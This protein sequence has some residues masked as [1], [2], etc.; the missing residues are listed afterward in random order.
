MSDS[1]QDFRI[2]WH[3]GTLVVIPG[4]DIE[5]MKWD[6]IE[7]AAKILSE[8]RPQTVALILAHL[9]PDHCASLMRVLP[10]SLRS[11][12]IQRMVDLQPVEQSIIEELNN[13]MRQRVRAHAT[14]VRP[15][16]AGKEKVAKLLQSIDRDSADRIL[17][18]LDQK[19]AP[20]A[21]EIKEAMFRFE[22]LT[23][24]HN[25]DLRTLYQSIAPE[26]WHLALLGKNNP[27]LPRIME[28]LS[29]RAQEMLRDD[30]QSLGN[31]VRLSSV[32]SAQKYILEE[33]LRLLQ[34]GTIERPDPS[35]PYV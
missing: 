21:S 10:Q 12:L 6:L 25:P 26:H 35:D 4:G 14:R 17:N 18:E 28:I 23:E 13:T 1:N 33:A 11:E 32:L 19:N 9:S 16:M 29:E 24:F 7:Q 31:K 20:L 15:P 8:E 27:M 22:D 5:S 3:S 30:I 34:A 2:E